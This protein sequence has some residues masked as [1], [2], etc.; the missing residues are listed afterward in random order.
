MFGRAEGG[1]VVLPLDF[2]REDERHAVLREGERAVPVQ[3]T[4]ELVEDDDF[5]EAA[6]CGF[7]PVAEFARRRLLPDAGKAG[8]DAGIEGVAFG[9]PPRLAFRTE[10]VVKDGFAESWFLLFGWFYLPARAR[11]CRMPTMPVNSR[12]VIS[13]CCVQGYRFCVVLAG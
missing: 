9:E 4:R 7:A 13:H 8:A 11:S 12:T 5:G 10:P 6:A 1:E 2:L 3:V